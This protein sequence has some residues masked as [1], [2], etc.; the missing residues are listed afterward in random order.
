MWRRARAMA[1]PFEPMKKHRAEKAL[2]KKGP[3]KRVG[4]GRL[5]GPT[6]AILIAAERH[7]QMSAEGWTPEHDAKHRG[8]QLAKAAESYLC[9][10]TQP[11]TLHPKNPSRGRPNWNWPWAEKWWKPN[12]DPVR[13]L[14]KAGALIAAEIDRLQRLREHTAAIELK[15]GRGLA[16]S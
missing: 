1:P 10:H 12:A 4:T 5:G 16:D 8:K 14:V 6:G 11:D 7:R 9:S 15:P 2:P 13:N 3:M